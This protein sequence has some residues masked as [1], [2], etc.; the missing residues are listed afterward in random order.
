[1]FQKN[2]F[3]YCVF[4][5]CSFL[6][7]PAQAGQKIVAVQSQHLKPFEIALNGFKEIF[8][9]DIERIVIARMDDD[10]SV[11]REI[12][13]RSPDVILAI[14][15]EALKQVR[16]I[17]TVPVVY[18]MVLHPEKLIKNRRNIAGV[19]M[20]IAPEKQLATLVTAL[21]G[22]GKI[23]IVYDPDE[24]GAFVSA[25]KKIAPRYDCKIIAEKI[26][27][28]QDAPGALLG[29]VDKI[30]IF[31]MMPD[32]SL[33]TP[34]TVD[35]IFDL[36]LRKNKPVIS[37]AEKYVASGAVLSIGIDPF[38]IGRQSAELAKKILAS[39]DNCVALQ[40]GPRKPVVSVSQI[41][42]KALITIN[43]QVVWN[44]GLQIDEAILRNAHI[45]N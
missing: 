45:L 39:E 30:D 16:D 41:A 9:A 8:P 6:C 28:P 34:L 22:A 23:G 18:C 29:M 2:I 17:H 10:S 1:M 14:G 12:L 19:S 7:G 32:R 42:R 43:R 40:T 25:V 26:A 44:L 35:Y 33:I 36:C 37:F 38:D 24:T 21:P 4:F 31:W 5:L 11:D 3:I 15:N 27:R 20:S 13:N